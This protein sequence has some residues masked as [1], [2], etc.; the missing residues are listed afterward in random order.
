MSK[1]KLY[2]GNISSTWTLHRI[3]R[4]ILTAFTPICPFFTHYL[5]KTLYD[6][7]SVDIR[8]FPIIPESCRLDRFGNLNELS[9]QIVSFNS[10]IWKMKKD[11][12]LSLKSPINDVEIPNDLAIF[13]SVLKDMHN[14]NS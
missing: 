7:S 14:I 9:E 5:S 11:S 13:S 1:S 3:V 2:S 4:D 6:I 8:E 12:S 10:K